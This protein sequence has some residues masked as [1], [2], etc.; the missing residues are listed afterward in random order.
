M[1]SIA[2]IEELKYAC[3]EHQVSRLTKAH[4]G[5]SMD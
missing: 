4:E 3:S 2:M 1:E 5:A